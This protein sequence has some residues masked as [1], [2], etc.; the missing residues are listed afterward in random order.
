MDR[1]RTIDSLGQVEL[2]P[3][4]IP[5]REEV[6]NMQEEEEEEDDDDITEE[7]EIEALP[8][9]TLY[10]T[11]L[12][13]SP[14]A[15]A[16]CRNSGMQIIKHGFQ[17]L[18][19][20]YKISGYENKSPCH[21][22][23]FIKFIKT[24]LVHLAS[25]INRASKA[26][27][28]KKLTREEGKRSFVLV[29]HCVQLAKYLMNGVKM[30][31][32]REVHHEVKST[33]I[34]LDVP[35]LHKVAVLV[36]CFISFSTLSE[37]KTTDETKLASESLKNESRTLLSHLGL[38]RT[39]DK[40]RT[41]HF[42]SVAEV[43][44]RSVYL[45]V[46][47][48]HLLINTFPGVY[49]NTLVPR[50]I[51]DRQVPRFLDGYFMSSSVTLMGWRKSIRDYMISS[52]RHH[53]R[54]SD[55]VSACIMFPFEDYCR[56]TSVANVV[57][58]IESAIEYTLKE[59][60]L[61]QVR[62][63]NVLLYGLVKVGSRGDFERVYKKY[64][65]PLNTPIF[66]ICA[67]HSVLSTRTRKPTKG[68]WIDSE[69][70]AHVYLPA[71]GKFG[72]PLVNV[73][74]MRANGDAPGPESLDAFRVANWSR[75]DVNWML[76]RLCSDIDALE[77]KSEEYIRHLDA[78]TSHAVYVDNGRVLEFAL[79]KKPIGKNILFLF[80]MCLCAV[81]C[82]DV[83]MKLGYYQEVLSSID[84]AVKP[85]MDSMTGC[86]HSLH[87]NITKAGFQVHGT[88]LDKTELDCVTV[89]RKY[90]VYIEWLKSRM[91][92]MSNLV[93][94]AGNDV[95]VFRTEVEMIAPS[96]SKEWQER[97]LE[98]LTRY[99]KSVVPVFLKAINATKEVAFDYCM[100]LAAHKKSHSGEGLL[101]V[102]RDLSHEE[103]EKI[104]AAV[105]RN[106]GYSL[107]DAITK[108]VPEEKISDFAGRLLCEFMFCYRDGA[109]EL[110]IGEEKESTT[111]LKKMRK[112]FSS[113]S[114]YKVDTAVVLNNLKSV[115]SDWNPQMYAK[116]LKFVRNIKK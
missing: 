50:F 56:D 3:F 71:S 2:P 46:Q 22:T 81:E 51:E 85:S 15:F 34:T 25:S 76:E 63:L 5:R 29:A 47:S 70:S 94:S 99:Q 78:L 39:P 36:F 90:P 80:T 41:P 11:I 72:E 35:D 112:L 92:V 24:C 73:R 88:I 13:Q 105:I 7:E 83:F 40:E 103:L 82:L 31:M 54:H 48:T 64:A 102:L 26:S 23:P 87:L 110:K 109:W 38:S 111:G 18:P 19:I 106:K 91:D 17:F 113:A 30:A 12:Y 96:M 115:S 101:E 43:C 1:K 74:S 69:E 20:L 79:K 66:T 75:S 8:S 32:K 53:W 59:V 14:S 89:L 45:S 60:K 6:E 9:E 93:R 62:C 42:E 77:M 104:G 49:T 16:L 108:A 68:L 107:L 10:G 37:L 58:E 95:E 44:Y 100:K 61:D 98:S 57:S 116:L 114:G 28:A 27:V 4:K 52:P 21:E 33:T 97:A 65:N 84:I 67:I 55:F 86:C